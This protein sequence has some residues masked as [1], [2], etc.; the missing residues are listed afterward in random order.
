MFILVLKYTSPLSE[1]DN[2]LSAHV[3]YLNKYYT[4][5]KFICS[6]RQNPR[7]GGIILCT[8]KDINEVNTII[9]DDPFYYNKLAEYEI[10]EFSPTKYADELKP[11][12]F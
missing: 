11:L 3:E 2:T 5:G 10:I 12:L 8:A 6:G 1:I 7:I 4:L 9:K